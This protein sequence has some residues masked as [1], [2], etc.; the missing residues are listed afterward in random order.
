M[1]FVPH[2]REK[3]RKSEDKQIPGRV[4][5]DK[6]QVWEAHGGNHAEHDKEDAADD[7]VGYGEEEGSELAEHAKD[8]HDAGTSL[9]YTS[10]SNLHKKIF[11]DIFQL[12]LS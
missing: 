7:G 2:Q 6:L 5:V 10:A 11:V 9:D 12:P 4:Q 1:L 8:D 3:E